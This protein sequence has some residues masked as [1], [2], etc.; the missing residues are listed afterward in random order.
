MS[1][2]TCRKMTGFEELDT[3][4]VIKSTLHNKSI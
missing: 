1:K 2:H 4:H 3:D